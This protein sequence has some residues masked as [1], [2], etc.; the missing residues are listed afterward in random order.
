MCDDSWCCCRAES[1]SERVMKRVCEHSSSSGPWYHVFTWWCFLYVF[2]FTAECAVKRRLSGLQLCCH[3]TSGSCSSIC[4][5]WLVR[6]WQHGVSNNV[7]WRCSAVAPPTAGVS[8]SKRHYW[9]ICCSSVVSI[10]NVSSISVYVA[11]CATAGWYT[12]LLTKTV[13]SFVFDK[14]Q[15]SRSF[16]SSQVGRL[17]YYLPLWALTKGFMIG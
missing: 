13:Q 6:E 8:P 12:G 3:E 15:N 5:V 7:T 17:P 4:R 11:E 9:V 2:I 16:G 10:R 1:H 14:W